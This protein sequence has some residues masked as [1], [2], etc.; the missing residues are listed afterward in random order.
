MLQ[1]IGFVKQKE[2]TKGMF[3]V[4]NFAELKSEY[5]FDIKVIVTLPSSLAI[6][7]D[8]TSIYKICAY[9]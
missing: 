3:Q 6:N 8:Y 7:W 1:C 5:L 4:D 2:T 9:K